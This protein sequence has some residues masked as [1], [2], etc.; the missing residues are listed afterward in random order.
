MLV[1][2]RPCARSTRA[3][4]SLAN[5]RKASLTAVFGKSFDIS[6]EDDFE[7]RVLNAPAPLLVDFHA[8]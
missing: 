1:A 7:R 4:W 8:G 2:I 3:A 6:D 5:A